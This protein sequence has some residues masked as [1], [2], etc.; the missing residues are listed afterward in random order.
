MGWV[1]LLLLGAAGTFAWIYSPSSEK[2]KEMTSAFVKQIEGA[3]HGTAP[4]HHV[5]GGRL[6]VANFDHRD[7]VVAEEVPAKACVSGGW[8][9]V[10]RGSL[11]IN[12]VTPQRVSAALLAEMCSTEG[13]ATLIWSPKAGKG[14]PTE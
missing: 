4:A 13:G 14:S 10:Q 6:R 3:I 12:G 11:S 8:E 9:L 1:I 7:V 5:F 2:T